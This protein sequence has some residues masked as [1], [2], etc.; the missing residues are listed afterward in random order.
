MYQS[1]LIVCS[2]L[3]HC[4]VKYHA[5]SLKV[6]WYHFYYTFDTKYRAENFTD[7]DSETNDNPYSYA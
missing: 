2:W 1:I 3:L 6:E 7:I 5:F 4:L